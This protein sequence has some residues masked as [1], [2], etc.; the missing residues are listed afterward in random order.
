MKAQPKS[1][2]IEIMK[3]L[4][5]EEPN[6]FVMEDVEI[7][8][9]KEGEAL[10]RI[11]RIGICGTDFHAYR[12]R[13]PFFTYPRILGHELSGEI[14]EIQTNEHG[15][16]IGDN[17]AIIPYLECGK[18]IACRNGKTNCCTELEL[19]GVHR[20]GG[21]QEYLAVPVTHLM[22]TNDITLDQAAIVE[23]LSIGAHAVRRADMKKAEFAIVIGAGPIG[24][25]VM[26]YAKLAGAQV[27]AIDMNEQRLNFCREWSDVDYT[28]NVAKSDAL[29]EI[30]KI[31]N[32]EFAITVFDATGNANSMNN[33]YKFASH[34]GRIIFVGLVQADI[35]FPDPEFHR[36]EL[37]LLSSRNATRE[38]LEYVVNT[39]KQG[40]VN[41]DAF[42]TSKT[43][44]DEIIEKFETF[45][46]PGS[47]TIK[48]MI[49]I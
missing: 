7:P 41:T 26:K 44:F 28:V 47:N 46:E 10:I 15:F 1:K 16:K 30:K 27:I 34:G 40:H 29:E 17:V 42:I 43:P 20:D 18:C 21:M 5:C 35:S 19:F 13:Q 48:A 32:G 9:L 33:A 31:T 36:R 8:R 6:R 23:C 25:G 4:I 38:D 11:R 39:I 49:S 12:G 2:E 24:L 37:T 3:R 22:K 14:A 45:M